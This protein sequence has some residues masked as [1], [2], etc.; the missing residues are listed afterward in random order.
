VGSYGDEL[1]SLTE[2]K[3]SPT[4]K[5]TFMRE[6]RECGIYAL[7]DGRE[8]VVHAVFRGGYTLYTQ[9]AWEFFGLHI[10]ETNEAGQI[11][12]KG[13]LTSWGIE[14]LMDTNRTAQP[15][16]MSGAAQKPFTGDSRR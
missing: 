8:F 7:P 5:A 13:R 11:R 14:D 9:G 6:L 4:R 2:R 1:S 3:L 16:S 15:R 12:T 10:Y